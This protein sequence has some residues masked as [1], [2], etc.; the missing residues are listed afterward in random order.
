M[1][2]GLAADLH[3]VTGVVLV[4]VVRG[5]YTPTSRTRALCMT[6]QNI[7][8]ESVDVLSNNSGSGGGR[9]QYEHICW[10]S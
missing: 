7:A 6:K 10:D 3:T 5:G 2:Q 1:I 9:I 8:E 4:D